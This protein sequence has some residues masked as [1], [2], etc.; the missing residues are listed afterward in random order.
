MTPDYYLSQRKI[1]SRFVRNF[2]PEQQKQQMLKIAVGPGGGEPRWTEW[3]EAIMKAYQHHTW[4]WDINGL[5]MHNYRVMKWPPA[6]TS[7]GFGETEYVQI[8][9]ST[10]DMEELID[11]HSAIMDKY[12]PEKKVALVVDEW[13]GWY[14]RCPAAILVFWCN[15]TTCGTQ[16]WRH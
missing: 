5:S 6:F 11:K 3:T 2:N 12:D 15:R 13:G 8:L 4:S 7:T 9:K 16:S 1:Y 10:L 14:A